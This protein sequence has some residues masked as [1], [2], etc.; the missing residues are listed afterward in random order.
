MPNTGN[1][2]EHLLLIYR[3]AVQRISI[4]IH[5]IIYTRPQRYSFAFQT[6]KRETR[7]LTPLIG[8]LTLQI[9]SSVLSRS[10]LYRNVPNRHEYKWS[11][12]VMRKRSLNSNAFKNC[13]VICQTQSMNCRKTGDLSASEWWSS[14]WPI[15]C[16]FYVKTRD[17]T[18]TW[19][20]TRRIK[21]MR[22]CWNLWP[23]N[24]HSFSIRTWNPLIVR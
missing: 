21:N 5:L 20:K 3:R 24:N 4:Q 9:P 14:P 23:N 16:T 12:I 18:H 13:V 19:K 7:L 22:T 10:L 8:K 2:Y 17:V 1:R 11:S 15:R 6:L